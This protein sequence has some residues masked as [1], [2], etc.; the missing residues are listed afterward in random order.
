[1]QNISARR[2]YGKDSTRIL[3]H[4]SRPTSTTATRTSVRRTRRIRL[5][6]WSSNWFGG[7][8][9]SHRAT[10]HLR[11][12]QHLG[13]EAIGRRKAGTLG[14]LH[15][16]TN[17]WFSESLGPVS[18]DREK[19][20]P[21]T[22]GECTHAHLSYDMSVHVQLVRT[23]L[24]HMQSPITR[25]RVA[26]AQQ[27]VPKIVRHPR[28]MSRPLPHATL[29]SNTSFHL[30]HLSSSHSLPHNQVHSV[31]TFISIAMIHGWVAESRNPH[32][33]QSICSVC[34]QREPLTRESNVKT[35]SDLFAK[36]TTVDT[37]AKSRSKTRTTEGVK[38]VESYCAW[39]RQPVDQL[40]KVPAICLNDEISRPLWMRLKSTTQ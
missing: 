38:C 22:D 14:I 7:S 10:C 3:N 5:P 15:G 35:Q 20:F 25:T 6:R 29:T 13:I 16:L 36:I 23:D 31:T 40:S 21:T 8:K 28:V 12:R 34:T 30:P 11:P 18:V 26:Q 17:S 24:A 1:M 32:L 4:P 37:E 33:P 19:N 39:A 27:G 2:I 9:R